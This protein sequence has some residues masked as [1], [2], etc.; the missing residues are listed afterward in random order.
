MREIASDRIDNVAWSLL[1]LRSRNRPVE[2]HRL[3]YCGPDPSPI[4]TLA[5]D[6][7]TGQGSRK[8]ER[9]FWPKRM[10]RTWPAAGSQFPVSVICLITLFRSWA[11]LCRTVADR[12][13]SMF[14]SF[15]PA[16]G[17]LPAPL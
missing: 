14:V 2:E 11:R 12:P 1:G 5:Y 9:D 15:C 8:S 13:G 16:G 4:K 7:M 6:R 3:Q 17:L 10:L